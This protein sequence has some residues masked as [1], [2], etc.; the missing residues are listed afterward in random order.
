MLALYELTPTWLSSSLIAFNV[1]MTAACRDNLLLI[2]LAVIGVRMRVLWMEA[3]ASLI[4]DNESGAPTL[5]KRI[6]ARSKI[7]KAVGECIAILAVA[8][9]LQK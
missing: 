6:I 8:A 1:W 5:D 7:W 2:S 9:S 3:K 4:A